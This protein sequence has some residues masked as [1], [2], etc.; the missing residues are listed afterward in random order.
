MG[1][2]REKDF[3]LVVVNQA[4]KIMGDNGRYIGRVKLNKLV[5]LVADEF[6]FDLTKGWYKFGLFSETIHDVIPPG[7]LNELEFEENKLEEAYGKFRDKDIFIIDT[8]IR[9]IRDR[10]NL[11]KS[12]VYLNRIYDMAPQ[13]YRG[14]Y[15]SHRKMI[16]HLSALSKPPTTENARDIFNSIGY[17]VKFAGDIEKEIKFIEDDLIWDIFLEFSDSLYL[18]SQKIDSPAKLLTISEE[19]QLNPFEVLGKIYLH[20]ENPEVEEGVLLDVESIKSELG[21]IW[22]VLV[23]YSETLEGLRKEE[24]VER[25]ERRKEKLKPI[26]EKGVD[27][28]Y[29]TIDENNYFPTSEELKERLK[30]KDKTTIKEFIQIIGGD[31]SD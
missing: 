23:P 15:K 17:S 19:G 13:E 24:M 8:Y 10:F 16:S 20:S 26:L 6:G 1:E 12:Q 27:V 5:S 14:L 11:Y 25:H 18:L 31:Y 9:S 29:D 4:K 21:D 7:R 30:G 2:L 28:V 22:T 3:A